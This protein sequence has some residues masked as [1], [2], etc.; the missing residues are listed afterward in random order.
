MLK[1]HPLAWIHAWK[2]LQHLS[3]SW[4]SWS[5]A[6][7]AWWRSGMAWDEAS[8][9]TQW[10]RILTIDHNILLTRLS[11][12]FGIQGTALNWFRSYLSSRCFRVKCNN[13]LSSLY[14]Y[15]CGVPQG[16][17]LG[18]LLFVMYTT[19]L[20]TLISFMS[21][22]HHL[23]AT[24]NSSFPSIHQNSTLI[25]LTCK[26]LYNRSLPGWLQTF[27]LSTLLKLSFFLSD[28]NN[29][30]LKFTTLLSLQPTLLATL[31]LS[32]MNTLPSLTKSP[33]FLNPA[34]ITF[35]NFTVSAHISTSKQPAPLP[36]PLSILN[37][38]TVTL[39]ITTYRSVMT[40]QMPK[41]A[42]CLAW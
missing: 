20:S 35:M 16:S 28:L 2:H 21:L 9:M 7:T 31:A 10:M 36:P 18:P 24:H 6:V 40:V 4:H 30:F 34:T 26:M 17:V 12:W 14:T 15:L 11:S 25:S 3:S 42:C 23:Y 38:I 33:H 8:L 39:S 37:L 22:N 1:C 13:N 19:P 5:E 27:L 29:S 41:R 32:L